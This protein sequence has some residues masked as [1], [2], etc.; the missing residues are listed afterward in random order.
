MDGVGGGGLVGSGWWWW[1]QTLVVSQR[2]S[3]VK[4][5]KTFRNRVNA[6]TEASSCAKLFVSEISWF[7]YSAIARGFSTQQLNYFDEIHSDIQKL[8]VIKQSCAQRAVQD[9]KNGDGRILDKK[10]RIVWA[11]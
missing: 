2:K 9:Y 3:F 7:N 11:K 4:L 10:E 8:E 6:A 5:R 1:W